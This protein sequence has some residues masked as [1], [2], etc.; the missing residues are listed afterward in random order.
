MTR[1]EELPW[2]K[3]QRVMYARVVQLAFHM[4]TTGDVLSTHQ[5]DVIGAGPSKFGKET[6]ICS[7]KDP[8]WCKRFFY[9][10]QPIIRCLLILLCPLCQLPEQVIFE[11]LAGSSNSADLDG[12][13]NIAL[14]CYPGFILILVFLILEGAITPYCLWLPFV[15]LMVASSKNRL[16]AISKFGGQRAF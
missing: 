12:K 14:C 1:F 5:F 4:T 6:D 9:H 15:S 8:A 16:Q 13:P 2:D 11:F 3:V 7:C 10:S